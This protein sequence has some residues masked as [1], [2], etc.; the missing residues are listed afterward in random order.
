M[1]LSEDHLGAVLG[2][3]PRAA[4]MLAPANRPSAVQ[5]ASPDGMKLTDTTGRPL[6]K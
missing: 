1:C 5:W 3:L 4:F 6:E 2:G